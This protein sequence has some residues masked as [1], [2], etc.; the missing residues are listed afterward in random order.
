MSRRWMQC[1]LFGSALAMSLAAC[2]PAMPALIRPEGQTALVKL[3][4]HYADM[5]AGAQAILSYTDTA[6]GGSHERLQVVAGRLASELGALQQ[7]FEETTA[8]LRTDQLDA[9]L[10]LWER[11]AMAQAGLSMLQQEAVE[12]GQDPAVDPSE[13]QAV[14]EQ[15]EAVLELA[16]AGQQGALENLK[17]PAQLIYPES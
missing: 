4:S 16:L 17:P 14:A 5:H 12:L 10:P 11:M 15:L 3:G 2:A 1:L 13:L 7:D 9:I 8:A 6:N